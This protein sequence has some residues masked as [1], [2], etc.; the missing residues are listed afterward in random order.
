M[1]PKCQSGVE[2]MQCDPHMFHLVQLCFGWIWLKFCV[3]S[4]HAQRLTT[5][6]FNHIQPKV[7][8]LYLLYGWGH[9]QVTN[10][11]LVLNHLSCRVC[12]LPFCVGDS[13]GRGN[14]PNVRS[15]LRWNCNSTV[16]MAPIAIA[17][18]KPW[19]RQYAWLWLL[20]S[21]VQIQAAGSLAGIPIHGFGLYLLIP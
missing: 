9:V 18:D 14:K 3:V 6:N 10:T 21:L 2:Y 11:G 8:E 4:L 19:I 20:W 7:T 5:Q 12:C 1:L 13:Q 15:I 16:Q 17:T